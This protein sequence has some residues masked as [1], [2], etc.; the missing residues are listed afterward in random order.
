M[1]TKSSRNLSTIRLSTLELVSLF[2]KNQTLM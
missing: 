2:I 1:G